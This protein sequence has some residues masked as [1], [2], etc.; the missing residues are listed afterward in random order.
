LEELLVDYEDFLRVRDAAVWT[1]ESKEAR[2]VRKLGAK[3]GV[4]YEDFREFVETRPRDVVANIALRLVHQANY[5][6]DQQTKQL[7]L[8][9][10]KEG[11]LRERTSRAR[12]ESRG[13]AGR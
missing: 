6:L 12:R 7:E 1:K 8:A 4:G 13:R 5:L 2:F 3:A 11:E 9:S 10:V